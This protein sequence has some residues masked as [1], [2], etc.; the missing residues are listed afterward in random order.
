[1]KHIHLVVLI[2]FFF[3]VSCLGQE[4]S[5]SSRV[6]P[7]EGVT[8]IEVLESTSS[9]LTLHGEDG[10]GRVNYLTIYEKSFDIKI[11]SCLSKLLNST[12][13]DIPSDD[14]IPLSPEFF[15]FAFLDKAGKT[16]MGTLRMIDGKLVVFQAS[17]GVFISDLSK[18]RYFYQPTTD[19]DEIEFD[20][21]R[22]LELLRKDEQYNSF[23]ERRRLK[24]QL[25]PGE[26]PDG[27][28]RKER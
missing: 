6:N 7:T 14:D 28:P 24:A 11:D 23:V 16:W 18:D 20:A 26:A 17:K 19:D 2:Q 13:A 21:R 15:Y 8:R 10:V 1:M 5:K 3:G 25:I 12:R 27:G 22:L 9:F 4:D